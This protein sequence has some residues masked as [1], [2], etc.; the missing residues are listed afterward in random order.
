MSL[1][2]QELNLFDLLRFIARRKWVIATSTSVFVLA[3]LLYTLFAEPIY[4][5]TAVVEIGFKRPGDPIENADSLLSRLSLE[6]KLEERSPEKRPFP[7]VY[8][9]SVFKAGKG[10][11]DL[12]L[13]MVVE[14]KDPE[15]VKAFAGEASGRLLTD[16]RARYDKII[17]VE[18]SRIETM[19]EVLENARTSLR[20]LE[21]RG[22]P[23]RS[24]E[25]AVLTHIYEQS[26]LQQN[27][28]L[29][30]NQLADRQVVLEDL[31]EHPPK[32][33]SQ[34][35]APEGPARPMRALILAAALILGLVTGAF[36]ALLLEAARHSAGNK[37]LQATL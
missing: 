31:L 18:T 11:L 37:R 6:H 28:A 26:S 3:G 20:H 27:I 10:N 2:S 5:A 17:A 4:E 22:V 33:A 23:S 16:L 9:V 8:E 32:L 15:S 1:D 29:I 21:T 36:I 24:G 19:R 30:Q 34:P 12:F 13:S 14:G 35:V 25:M 7:R